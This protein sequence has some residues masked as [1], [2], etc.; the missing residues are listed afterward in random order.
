M[1]GRKKRGEVHPTT[2]IIRP[3]TPKIRKKAIQ[4]A[5]N[6]AEM[7]EKELKKS[8]KKEPQGRAVWKRDE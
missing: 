2:Q 3:H 4:T 6:P 7:A 5:M 1:C 8:K